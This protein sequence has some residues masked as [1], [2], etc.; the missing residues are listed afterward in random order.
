VKIWRRT[1]GSDPSKDEWNAKEINI[2]TP[3][4]KVSWS[5][6]GNLLAVSGGDNQVLVLKEAPNGEWDTVSKVNEEGVLE[7]VI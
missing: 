6:V 1:P 7:D 2:N 3:G 4:W 5:Q